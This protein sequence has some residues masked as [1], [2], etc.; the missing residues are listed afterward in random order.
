M[1]AS[2]RSRHALVTTALL[3]GGLGLTAAVA[4]PAT[5]AGD[6]SGRPLSTGLTGAEEVPGP[7]DPDGSGTALLRVNPGRGTLCYRLSVQ[8]IAGATGAHLHE[9]PTGEAGPIVVPLQPPSDGTSSGCV[10][11]GRALAHDIVR[12][13]S[14]YY[15]NVH[16]AAFPKGALRGQLG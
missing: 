12:D 2:R 6:R 4:S 8:E 10:N 3:C 11:I 15:V 9:A 5:A 13:P 16:N 1:P 7:G 14:D